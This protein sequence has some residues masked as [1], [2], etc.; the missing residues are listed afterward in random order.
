M[1]KDVVEAGFWKL[2]SRMPVLTD[3]VQRES[4]IS[5]GLYYAERCC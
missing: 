2:E 3:A 1:L 5:G 4:T